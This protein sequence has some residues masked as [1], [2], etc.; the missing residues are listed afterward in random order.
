MSKRI[1]EQIGSELYNQIKEK[2]GDKSFDLLDGWVPRNELN[3][4]AETLKVYEDKVLSYEKQLEATKNMLK[5]TEEYKN[6]YSQ[7]E[8]TFKDTLKAKDTE[9]TNVT[10]RFLVKDTLSKSGAKHVDLLMKQI[11]LDKLSVDN[12]KLIGIDEVVTSYSDLFTETNKTSTDDKKG[13]KGKDKDNNEWGDLFKR[14]S[15]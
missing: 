13:N 3:K 8:N 10:K 5:D 15:Y 2:L 12:D 6:K 7:L 4:K 14:L 9:L 1:E 11:D